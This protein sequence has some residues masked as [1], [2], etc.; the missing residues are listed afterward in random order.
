[1]RPRQL[2]PFV[3]ALLAF[4]LLLSGVEVAIADVHDGDAS[5]EEIAATGPKSIACEAGQRTS[6][7]DSH[8][9]SSHEAHVCHAG[10]AHV[11]LVAQRAEAPTI[12]LPVR[13]SVREHSK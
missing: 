12:N 3:S 10:H 6:P 13:A 5:A 8:S 4:S 2:R 11:I 1:M 7:V 9:Q